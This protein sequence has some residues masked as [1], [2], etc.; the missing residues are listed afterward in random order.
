M[1]LG[2]VIDAALKRIG[3]TRSWLAKELDVSRSTVARY[4]SG[5]SVPS[6]VHDQK[7]R[8]ILGIKKMIHRVENSRLSMP[9]K[10]RL[11]NTIFV[12][13]QLL[14]SDNVFTKKETSSVELVIDLLGRI[15]SD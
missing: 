15:S 2:M 1:T 14:V 3:K 4:C 13:R 10:N 12:L 9:E 6:R 7:L 8:K 11:I 5:E